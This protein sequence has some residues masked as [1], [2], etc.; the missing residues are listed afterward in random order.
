LLGQ[1]RA[2]CVD[3]LQHR[4]VISDKE[5]DQID[6]ALSPI[7]ADGKATQGG[8]EKVVAAYRL[9]GAIKPDEKIDSAAL[10]DNT[11]V[12]KP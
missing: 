2:K 5:F 4:R 8:I 11:W 10:F 7:S 9:F 6:A 3:L 1:D 12:D